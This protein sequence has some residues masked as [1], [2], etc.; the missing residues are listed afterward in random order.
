MAW[1]RPLDDWMA[2]RVRKLTKLAGRRKRRSVA[3][4]AE[5]LEA[6]RLLTPVFTSD[7]E[8]NNSADTATPLVMLG[9]TAIATGTITTGDHDYYSFTATAGSRVW[10]TT[11]T[12]GAQMAGASSRDSV[13]DLYAT[14]GSTVIETDDDDGTG[15]GGDGTLET[16]LA[17]AI[18]GRVLP[19]SGTYYI[20]MRAF[21]AT[22][23]INPYRLFVTVTSTE[24]L[25]ESE[26]NGTTATA[27]PID[28]AAVYASTIGS[29]GDVDY[30][31]F[32]ADAGD[33][34]QLSADGDPERDGTG[35]D[36][37]VQLRDASD[38]QL[39]SIDSSVAGSGINPVA[40]TG[41]YTVGAAGT[42]YVR[43]RHFSAAATTGTYHLTVAKQVL[44]TDVTVNAD[45]DPGGD[46]VAGNNAGDIFRL[47]RA[48]TNLETWI[49][50]ELAS[51]TVF[52][53]IAS[54][55]VNGSGDDDTLIMDLSGGDVIPGSLT[56]N[57]GDGTDTLHI[58]DG[59]QGIVTYDYDTAGMFLTDHGQLHYAGLD[60]IIN[61]SPA[62]DMV[63]N[64]P[65]GTENFFAADD[66]V[67]D[68]DTSRLSGGVVPTTFR[69]PS[70]S[71][72]INADAGD[73]LVDLTESLD[74]AS[75]TV[76][77]PDRIFL[78]RVTT[79]GTVLLSADLFITPVHPLPG[80]V[81]TAGRLGMTAG[82]GIG[83]S[84][85]VYTDVRQL[86]AQ[87]T[88]GGIFINNTGD[89]TIGGV[90]DALTGLHAGT[91]GDIV[92]T[93]AGAITL[94]D[95]DGTATVR[96][97]DTSGNV[98]L[99]ASGAD[100]DI[101][102]PVNHHAVSAPSGSIT[103]VAGRDIALGAAGE[104][105]DNEV[106]AD[107][108]IGLTAGRTITVAGITSVVAD[109]FNN[110]TG[111]PMS[112]RADEMTFG[113]AASLD[114][115]AGVV[116]LQPATGNRTVDLGTETDGALGLT[117][118][119]LDRITTGILRVSSLTGPI[120]ITAAISGSSSL[121][122]G[123]GSTIT[124]T[125]DG[126]LS[127]FSLQASSGEGV[128]LD[129]P[130]ND[131]A[132]VA[133]T[134]LNTGGF[135]VVNGGSISVGSV[136]SVH[137]ITTVDGDIRL[138]AVGGDLRLQQPVRAATPDR[139]VALSAGGWIFSPEGGEDLVVASQLALTAGDRIGSDLGAL[140]TRVDRLAFSSTTGPVYIS[141]SRALTIAAVDTLTASVNSGLSTTL[142]AVGPL[143]F[144]VNTTSAGS[145][146][147]ASLDQAT[148]GDD[149][150][151]NP[152]VT[153]ASTGGDV[154][155]RAGDTVIVAVTAVVSG[156]QVKIGL[157][158]FHTGNVDT[159]A[160]FNSTGTF[161]TS[162]L[163]VNG[164]DGDDTIR[165]TGTAGIAGS[166]IVQANAGLDT[167]QVTPSTVPVN[168]D[169]GE[170]EGN[171][172]GDTLIYNGLG[173]LV[174]LLEAGS[175]TITNLFGLQTVQFSGM[176]TVPATTAGSA[177]LVPNP[178][179]PTRRVLQVMGTAASDT[180]TILPRPGTSAVRVR[181]NGVSLGDFNQNRIRRIV[182]FGLAGHDKIEVSTDLRQPGELYGH[183]GNDSLTGGGGP[184]R[185]FGGD[186]LDK[187]QG[188]DGNDVLSGD[189]G[190]D[191][192]FGQGGDD[193]LWGGNGSDLLNGGDGRDVL[194]GGQGFDLLKGGAGD[195]ILIGGM[196]TH[197]SSEPALRAILA[198]WASVN[199]YITRA[200]RL[201]Q[202][203][204]L[205]TVNRLVPEAT[206]RDDGMVDQ[207]FGE[208][209]LDWFFNVGTGS[210]VVN[211]R[212]IGEVVNLPLPV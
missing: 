117:D 55:T 86:E 8:S 114:A 60:H 212:A 173:G 159:G 122:L 79:T 179:N 169:G 134:V 170:S 121:S 148:A 89:L 36:L 13:I 101:T 139:L 69:H 67:A 109:G 107:S 7:T 160:T 93:N 72:T 80:V 64:L 165:V 149:I 142:S 144:A 94:S 171:T 9:R 174:A 141:N 161:R 52:A 58:T 103:L 118:E 185:L 204:G 108:H 183:Q 5:R 154:E 87:A 42:Y 68:N 26:D 116:S 21:S 208:G 151:V 14:N 22:G 200:L 61:E 164:N 62:T 199:A 16:G 105:F 3:A 11:D 20:R 50:G 104:D 150:L 132:S 56:F 129:N 167:I 74:N 136:D 127:G 49:N 180:L 43:V 92:L 77:G 168:V 100:S 53:T 166:V 135:V 111:G 84:D 2:R 147:A 40:E 172:P 205:N 191:Q 198:E 124:D 51:S 54:L 158:G 33:S 186:G 125:D 175:G 195:D 152:G 6:R 18:A 83:S 181:L 81:V 95:T 65:A 196:T 82:Q 47:V 202:G 102:S 162:T 23:V 96:G 32:T 70:D 133:G 163:T 207:L 115:G 201:I 59:S 119:E 138:T 44:S 123:S 192:L 27:S 211:D 38:T 131:L 45:S 39:L 177:A 76:T 156:A 176:E 178:L 194:I 120:E 24:A 88:T 98:S 78:S 113:A 184:D 57:G 193:L 85:P 19:D 10:I 30:Y 35:T 206:V 15:N 157:D 73:V 190:E 112:L 146:V 106:R 197:G 130:A 75:L 25:A 189:G 63:V 12:G 203:G 97:G 145:L 31:S 4:Q 128:T 1:P 99:T 17:S 140:N 188:G 41:N 143:I 153:L 182:A 66:D 137:G 29:A 28:N 46:N 37:V 110:Q 155:L 71:L 187:L 90:T 91:S 209:G 126:S 34:I 210:D 48:G